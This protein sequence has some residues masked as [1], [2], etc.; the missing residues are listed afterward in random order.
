MSVLHDYSLPTG[1]R[2][3]GI[4]GVHAGIEALRTLNNNNVETI[5]PVGVLNWTNEEGARFPMSM[6]SSGTWSGAI[7]LEEAYGL[8]EV[9]G[10]ATQM[11]ELERIG[12][13]GK[14]E[15]HHSVMPMGAHF[16]LHIEQRPILEASGRKIGVVEGAQAFRWYQI[17]VHGKDCHTGATNFENR[18]DALLTAAKMILHSHNKATELGCLAS[19]GILTLEPG[20]TNTIPGL[21]RFSLDM[22]SG[23]DSTLLQLQQVLEFDFAKIANGE[24]VG[25]VN[26]RGTKGKP[27][28]VEWQ[29]DTVSPAI[30]F[31]DDCI[32]C[33]EDSAKAIFGPGTQHSRICTEDDFR[34]WA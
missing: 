16:E 9:N 1:G 25:G 11:S 28:T 33:V 8:R 24:D 7:P 12:Y 17:K 19:I 29:V 2:Y 22:R 4:L 5:Y 6:V 34:S 18:S 14:L 26:S 20:S 21:V 30:K 31:H 32:Q 23:R 10:L 3:D 15:A 27:Y 13:R